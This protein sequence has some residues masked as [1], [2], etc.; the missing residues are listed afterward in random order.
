VTR[1]LVSIVTP[2]YNQA[3]FLEET[4]RSVL[5]QDY[6]PLEYIVVDDGSTDGSAA[7]V[8]RYSE[9]LAW[10][11][12]QEN[13]GQATALN[14]GFE[15]AQGELLGFVSSDDTLLP[16]SISHLAAAFGADAE[17]LLAYGDAL[18]VDERRETIGRLEGRRW[19]LREMAR[20]GQQAVPQPASLWSRRAWELAGPFNERAWALFD[21]EFYLRLA[22]RGRAAYIGG[23]LATFRLHP[24]SKEMSRPERMAADCERFADEFFGSA[25]LPPELRPY[26]R[27]G[28]ASFYRRAALGYYAAGDIRRARRLFLRSLIRPRGLRMKQLRRLVWTL[29]PE[30]LRRLRSSTAVGVER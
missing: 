19:D 24:A 11:T 18:Y 15:R 22:V 29:V 14:R 7:I 8:E 25:G 20:T 28:R 13:A 27:A 30:P 10:W 1:P 26:S 6:E 17:L 2:S 12:I 16:G 21:T 9:R 3:A 4:I 5:E 23:P